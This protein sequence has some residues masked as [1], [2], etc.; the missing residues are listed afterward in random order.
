MARGTGPQ[1]KMKLW[2]SRRK[3]EGIIIKIEIYE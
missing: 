1:V 3:R 2:R